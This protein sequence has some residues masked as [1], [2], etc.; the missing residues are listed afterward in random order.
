M[1]KLALISIFAI[2]IIACNSGTGDKKVELENLKKQEAEIKAKI[3]LLEA[4]LAANDTSQ[5]GIAIAVE[6]IKP[7]I[8]KNYIDVQGKVDADEN[9]AL[10]TEMPGT[11]NKI[12]V[13]VGYPDKPKN[14]NS[15][16]LNEDNTY[17]EN[18]LLCL[19]FEE[20]LSWK[21]LFWT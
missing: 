4:E 5:K 11:I 7:E 18:N 13:K 14:Y 3:L 19:K 20:D 10:S 8:F 21:K 6:K 17:L 1:K 9:V 2:T 12:N 16:V 15:L